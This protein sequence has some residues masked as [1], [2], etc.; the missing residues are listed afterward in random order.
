M[1]KLKIGKKEYHL[2]EN[3]FDISDE[4]FNV[5]K[6]YLLQ[7]FENLDNPS[8][9]TTFNKYVAFFNNGNHADGLIE[10][11]NF[12]KAIEL[13]GLNYDAY[14]MCFALMCMKEGED[15][16]DFSAN[17]QLEKLKEMRE[18]GLTRGLVEETVETFIKASPKQF[19]VYLAMLEL[20]KPQEK[21]ESLNA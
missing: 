19:T 10:W 18:Q 12:R 2:F 15:Q 4:R 20:M 1:K 14:S 11:Y 3:L 7:I 5:F 17:I 13:K 16:K 21:E 9:I 8:F 6:S